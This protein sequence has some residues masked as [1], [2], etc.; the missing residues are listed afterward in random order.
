[1]T[2]PVTCSETDAGYEMLSV[3]G[4]GLVGGEKNVKIVTGGAEKRSQ[5]EGPGQEVDLRAMWKTKWLEFGERMGLRGT[6]DAELSD[7]TPILSG[8]C[9]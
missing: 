6:G 9:I 1:M 8:P 7:G 5:G 3:S 4:V 2:F